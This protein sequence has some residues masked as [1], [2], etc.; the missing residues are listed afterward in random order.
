[1]T[2]INTFEELLQVLDENPEWANAPVGTWL[3]RMS[4]GN[5]PS[6]LMGEG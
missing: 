1:M 4:G 5:V 2:T 3:G 6:P